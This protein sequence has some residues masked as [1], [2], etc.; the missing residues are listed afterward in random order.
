MTRIVVIGGG[1][2]GLA[3]ALFSARH[4]HEVVLLERDAGPPEGTA[5]D[6]FD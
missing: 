2:G 6:D 5:D 4:G 3:A 1:L